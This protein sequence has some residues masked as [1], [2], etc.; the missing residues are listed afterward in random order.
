MPAPAVIPAP[1]A[2]AKVVAVEK[3]VVEILVETCWVC[4]RLVALGKSHQPC[5]DLVVS[6]RCDSS[7]VAAS[8]TLN[9]VKCSRQAAKPLNMLAW[10]NKIGHSSCLLVIGTCVMINRNCLGCLNSGGRGEI[11]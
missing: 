9:K 6:L 1:I 7:L 10:D 11:L 8:I 4:H 2:Y 3:L 5:C